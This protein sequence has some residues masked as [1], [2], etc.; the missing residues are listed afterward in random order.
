MRVSTETSTRL[1]AIVDVDTCQARGLPVVE[2]AGAVCAARP[3]CVQLRA[4]H[5][6]A[7]DTLSLLRAIVPVARSHGVLVFANDRPD[8]AMLADADGV[9]VGQDDLPVAR[10]RE[11]VPSLRVGV[12]THGEEQLR[13]ALAEIPD[14]IACGPIYPTASKTDAESAVGISGLAAAALMARAA[15]IP[16]VAIGGINRERVAEVAEHA[17]LIAMIAAL[18]PDS[19]R[20]DDVTEHVTRLVP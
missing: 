17:D 16:L 19:G 9:H 7:R 5:S 12:S 10:V 3:R 1:Y 14:Y 8:L 2:F 13:S 6:T 11:V 20:L 18:I 15:R 4:K